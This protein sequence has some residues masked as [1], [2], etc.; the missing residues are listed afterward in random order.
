MKLLDKLANNENQ[1]LTF[2]GYLDLKLR[3][4][5]NSGENLQI[6]WRNDGKNQSS[7]ALKLDL[8][9]LFNTSFGL[10]TSLNVF[11]QDSLFQNTKTSIKLN[12]LLPNDSQISLGLIQNSSNA[13]SKIVPTNLQDFE[14]S[15]YN[16]SFN[17]SKNDFKDIL[18]P[19]QYL[20]DFST[21]L[22]NRKNKNLSVTQYFISL[23]GFYHYI[24]ND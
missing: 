13:L 21:G 2:T 6:N 17:I 23:N 16:F 4:I 1:Q 3:N 5:I 24:L 20:V 22:G 8:P 10:E 12:Y 18:F 11:K 14:N 7:F 19:E 9:L 15:F